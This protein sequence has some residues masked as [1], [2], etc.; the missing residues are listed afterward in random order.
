MPHQGT[1]AFEV[2][3]DKEASN[4]SYRLFISYAAAPSATPSYG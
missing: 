4:L 2:T 1:V 3:P